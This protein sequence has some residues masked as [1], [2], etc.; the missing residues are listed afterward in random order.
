[1]PQ[2]W[3]SGIVAQ[4]GCDAA[5]SIENRRLRLLSPLRPNQQSRTHPHC[6]GRGGVKLIPTSTPRRN[7]L[8]SSLIFAP[9]GET[10]ARQNKL[11]FVLQFKMMEPILQ[12]PVHSQLRHG[13]LHLEKSLCSTGSS[14]SSAT[15]EEVAQ[16]RHQLL[17]GPRQLSASDSQA[18][19]A[20]KTG[21]SGV[22][23]VAPLPL[24]Q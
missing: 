12:T 18:R 13:T 23:A 3:S 16:R 11:I 19:R 1:M 21:L 4:R 24:N 7:G 20:C 9:S 10:G 15:A 14:G 17:L 8:G 2:S 5:R 22:L 6:R